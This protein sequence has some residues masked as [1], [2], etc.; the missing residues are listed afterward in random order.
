M[1]MSG[2]M[3]VVM[4]KLMV[5][6]VYVVRNLERI[7]L[8]KSALYMTVGN[9][10]FRK[11]DSELMTY[12]SDSSK[13]HIMV[14]NK[15]KKRVRDIKIISEEKIAQQHQLLV[16]GIMICA[17]KEVVKPYALKRKG[18]EVIGG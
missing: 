7:L 11:R 16:T 15:N 4:M 8:M 3:Q 17:V 1:E 13:N 5:F 12:K 14:R 10:V 18:M 9:T 2:S 6:R